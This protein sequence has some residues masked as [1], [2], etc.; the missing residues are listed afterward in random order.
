MNT[1][2]RFSWKQSCQAPQCP[3]ISWFWLTAAALGAI[4]LVR[5][6]KK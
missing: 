6:D 5:K 2:D 1:W 4:L 3:D